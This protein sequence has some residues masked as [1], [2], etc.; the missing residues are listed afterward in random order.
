MRES[1][2]SAHAVN[3]VRPGQGG[4]YSSGMDIQITT[5]AQRPELA[6]KLWFPDAWP[7]FMQKD[8]VANAL[9][10][11]IHETFAE[12]TLVATDEA[13]DV[14]ARAESVPF[15]LHAPGRGGALP[16]GG[17]DQVLIWAFHDQ[18]RG[19][20]PDLVSAIE[21]VVRL[22][23]QGKGL[24]AVMLDAMRNNAKDRGFAELV[25]PMRPTAKHDEPATPTTEYAR[26]TRPDGL[27]VD[28][29]LRTH[30]RAGGV[31]EA[32]APAT[33]TMSG[34]LGQWREWTGLPFDR[35]GWVEVPKALVPVYCS[36]EHDYAV[37]VEPN[38]W[39]RHSLK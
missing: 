31:I 25:A 4:G 1:I 38:V 34:S 28:P 21:V 3:S 19:V 11:R 32:V 20:E 18:R 10:G 14:V 39:V 29:W 15:A 12:F 5:L 24:S 22:D 8:L 23:Q 13:G 7:I 17:W 26:R 36:I 33:M 9:F 35:E 27:P 37:Y 16:A 2:S 30:F 6:D